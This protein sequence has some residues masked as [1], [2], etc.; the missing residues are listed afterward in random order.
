VRHDALVRL[1]SRR[2]GTLIVTGF[3][4]R[5]A[6]SRRQS[7]KGISIL[8]LGSHRR[9]IPRVPAPPKSNPEG[10]VY[11]APNR[12]GLVEHHSGGW[13]ISIPG[14]PLVE[15]PIG[16]PEDSSKRTGRSQE[17][18]P[19]PIEIDNPFRIGRARGR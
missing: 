18:R 2:E 10:I 17:S 11:S 12:A 1:V 3:A 19:A 8:A 7:L 14:R 6:V 15:F 4:E 9:W 16:L 5:D 13:C